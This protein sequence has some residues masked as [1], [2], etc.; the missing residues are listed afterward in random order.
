MYKWRM[1][2]ALLIAIMF[3]FG[4]TTIRLVTKDGIPLPQESIQ[5]T[6][7]QTGI[8]VES[9]F[10][11]YYEDSP[12]S[13]YPEYLEFNKINH[14]SDTDTQKTTNVILFLRIW[15]KREV[16]YKVIKYIRYGDGKNDF[17][18]SVVYKGKDVVRHFQ[19]EMPIV[20]DRLIQIQADVADG[21]GDVIFKLGYFNVKF[22]SKNI[23]EGIK[24][25]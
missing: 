3:A 21:E 15:N 13:I 18:K 5:I 24:I 17:T 10:I 14:L 25:K 19:L 16:P 4:C 11:R 20:E 7:P 1:R 22:G 6:N 8:T 12:E 2:L 23:D 9:V